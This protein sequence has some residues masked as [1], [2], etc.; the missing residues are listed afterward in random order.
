[1]VF[2]SSKRVVQ[3]LQRPANIFLYSPACLCFS[4]FV[5]FLVPDNFSPFK[6]DSSCVTEVKAQDVEDS[7]SPAALLLASFCF[8]GPSSRMIL[9]IE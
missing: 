7:P 9:C 4:T 6:Q 2:D 5:S 1:M 3:A 8:H